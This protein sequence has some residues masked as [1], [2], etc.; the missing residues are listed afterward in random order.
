VRKYFIMGK[1]YLIKNW[2]IL[3]MIRVSG[4]GTK[5]W[6]SSGLICMVLFVLLTLPV[7]AKPNIDASP[8]GEESNRIYLP[9]ILNPVSALPYPP[10][11]N[12]INNTDLDNNYSLT[13][14]ETPQRLATTYQVQEATDSAFT[15]NLR[16]ACVTTSL[17]CAVQ[18]P[19][20]GT[21]YYRVRGQNQ[22]GYGEWSTLQSVQSKA[23]ILLGIYP[24]YYVM[25]AGFSNE[26]V[27]IDEFVAGS[28]GR[29][30]TL[31]GLFMDTQY[32]SADNVTTHLTA[33]W[34]KGYTPFINLSRGG[35][36]MAQIASGQLDAELNNWAVNFKT[37]ADPDNDGV[38]ERMAFIAP[39]QEMNGDWVAYGLDPTNYKIAY[40]RIQNILKTKGVPRGAV[41]W[42][43]APNG[44]T[45]NNKP[46]FEQYYPG[47]NYVDVV[48]ISGYNFGYC[49]GNEGGWEWQ[50]A[51]FNN[52]NYGE[53]GYYLDRLRAMAPSKPIFIAQTGTTDYYQT[54]IISTGSKN[55]WL[56]NVYIYLANQTN[57]RGVVYFNWR[58][59]SWQPCNWKVYQY[60][61]SGSGFGFDGYKNAILQNP[62]YRYVAPA[63]V[64]NMTEF[65]NAPM[66]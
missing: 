46:L 12:A 9:V 59:D 35:Y 57:L 4:K 14:T 11:L 49:P 54:G 17:T 3:M 55:T 52:P 24:P 32:N 66:P 2:R 27:G 38:A 62:A 26:M 37:Y 39:F 16:E 6:L 50:T 51:V 43:F 44:W 19:A 21:Y 8:L 65:F 64:M 30:T 56:S 18:S 42:V 5:N 61:G 34:N 23:T 60:P 7:A 28:G 63:N 40:Y 10:V 22:Y 45:P 25:E 41:S 53:R 15:A 33:V 47:D 48:A 36:T 29:S 20:Y 13:W 58:N 31:A 1:E